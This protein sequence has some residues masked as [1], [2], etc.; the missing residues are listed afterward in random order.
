VPIRFGKRNRSRP[1]GEVP[2]LLE[3]AVSPGTR[4]LRDLLR[5]WLPAV[6]FLTLLIGGMGVVLARSQQQ[7]RTRL[8]QRYALRTQL[9]G[10]FVSSYVRD[11]QERE[12]KFA[13]RFLTDRV[14]APARFR[15]ASSAFDF[16]SAVLLD[17]GGRVLDVVPAKPALIGTQLDL[18]RL[19]TAIEGHSVVSNVVPSPSLSVPIVEFTVPFE[20]GSGRRVFSGGVRLERGALAAFLADALPYKGAR[21]YLIDAYGFVMVAGG[22]HATALTAPPDARGRDGSIVVAGSR[23]RFATTAVAGTPWHLLAVAPAAE[24]FAP[25]S[26]W[27]HWVPWVVLIAFA[28]AAATALSMLSR[29]MR[30][31]AELAHL[32]THDPLTGALNRRMLERDFQRLSATAQRTSTKVGVLAIDLDRFKHVNDVYGHAVGDDLLRRVA[33]TIQLTVRASDVVARIGGDEFVVLLADIGE[34]QAQEIAERVYHT[35]GETSLITSA[36]EIAVRCSVGV[37]LAT[38]DDVIDTVLARADG[39]MYRAKQ[40]GRSPMHA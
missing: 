12:R 35:L 7:S 39:A 34:E 21:I 37:A 29:L 20:A 9:A 31:R 19:R 13:S 18:P 10:H 14:V 32:A 15:V 11:T 3:V 24:L 30:Q 16:D 8:E 33:E 6:C 26:G 1:V 25:L 2:T 36:D 17:A 27:Q 23:Y 38:Q 28:L 5:V 22:S 4:S 40:K